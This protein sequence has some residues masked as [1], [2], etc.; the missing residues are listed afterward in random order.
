VIILD[1]NVV[2]EM[3]RAAPAAAVL[4]WI[5]DQDLDALHLTS[6]TCAEILSGIALLPEGRRRK[7]LSEQANAFFSMDFSDRI[8]DFDFRAAES[9]ADIVAT[10]VIAGRP[11]GTKD[12]MIAA[13][14]RR[15]SATVATR[16]GDFAGCGVLLINP[17]VA[18]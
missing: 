7:R 16:D 5:A 8:L 17:W 10:R 2:S 13:I 4:D 9:F 1:T 11:I 14:A 3:M 18:R 15:H 6:V 12:A